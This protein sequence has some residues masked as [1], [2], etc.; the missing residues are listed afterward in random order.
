[1]ET[2]QKMLSLVK[3][4]GERKIVVTH[5][6][7]RQSIFFLLL[8]LI[9]IELIA[10]ILVILFHELLASADIIFFN[11]PLFVIL[12]STKTA[13]MVFVIIQ[14]LEEYYEITPTEIIHK[15]GLLFK[16]E[17]RNML[18]HLNSLKIDQGLFGRIFNYG[19][20]TVH[21]WTTDKDVMLYLIHNPIKYNDIL[22]SLLPDI[23]KEKQV[24]REHFLEEETK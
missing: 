2:Q 8:K 3:E 14:W 12:V 20:L 1:M 5:L 10:A 16:K 4:A 15:R 7:I 22:Q 21:N 13:F 9:V 24:L 18:N 11:I 19:T 6:T 17:E 23:D